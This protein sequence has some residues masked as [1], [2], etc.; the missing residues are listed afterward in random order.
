MS[1]HLKTQALEAMKDAPPKPSVKTCKTSPKPSANSAPP[2]KPMN[3]FM[4]QVSK[5]N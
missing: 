4:H 3:F 2:P 1:G 5:V